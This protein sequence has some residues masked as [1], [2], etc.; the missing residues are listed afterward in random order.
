MLAGDAGG[1]ARV[2]GRCRWAGEACGRRGRATLV[3]SSMANVNRRGNCRWAVLV[4][5]AVIVVVAVVVVAVVVVVVVVVVGVV[6]V[7]G[8]VVVVVE[9][10]V[11]VL[12][13][14]V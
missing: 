6:G 12:V 1:N 8:V 2:I 5:V 13:E 9:V 10:V 11:C 4:A 7:V 14:A 3:E